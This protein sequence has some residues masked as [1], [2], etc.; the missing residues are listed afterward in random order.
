MD[1]FLFS[2]TARASRGIREGY[3]KALEFAVN[4]GS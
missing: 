2:Y 3:H 1:A 4:P